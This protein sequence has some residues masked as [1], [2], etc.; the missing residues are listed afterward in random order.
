MLLMSRG[1][2]H[3]QVSCVEVVKYRT[4][5]SS[6]SDSRRERP[7]YGAPFANWA[8]AVD[9]YYQHHPLH[10]PRQPVGRLSV[11]SGNLDEKHSR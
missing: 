4:L 7:H 5:F 9:P 2:A 11:D 6:A 3:R 1:I 8:Y 10:H